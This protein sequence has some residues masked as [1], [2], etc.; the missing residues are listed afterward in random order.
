MHSEGN[1][2]IAW[3]LGAKNYADGFLFEDCPYADELL[4]EAWRQG[5]RFAKLLDGY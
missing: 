2:A 3:K 5:Y 4:A 1:L